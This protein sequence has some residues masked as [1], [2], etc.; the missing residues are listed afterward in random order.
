MVVTWWI[1]FFFCTVRTFIRII[2]TQTV[3]SGYTR[4]LQDKLSNKFKGNISAT[5]FPKGSM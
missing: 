1:M 5:Q 3:G 2:M 4:R